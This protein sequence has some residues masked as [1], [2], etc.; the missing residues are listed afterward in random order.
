MH[1]KVSFL[2]R[3]FL[4]ANH[5]HHLAHVLDDS[6]VNNHFHWYGVS[7]SCPPAGYPYDF[8]ARDYGARPADEC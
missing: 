8:R 2:D 5:F 6:F 3:Q 4:V 1:D 7:A